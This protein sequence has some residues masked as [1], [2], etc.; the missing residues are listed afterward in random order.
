MNV[1]NFVVVENMSDEEFNV[2]GPMKA[3]RDSR[4]IYAFLFKLGPR[5]EGVF[6]AMPG[7]FCPTG[8]RPS[9]HYTGT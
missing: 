4:R 7:P 3:Q 8:K 9:T 2:E 6:K 1:E 5:E